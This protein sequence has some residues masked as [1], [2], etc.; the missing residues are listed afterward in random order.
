MPGGGGVGGG[1]TLDKEWKEG[2]ISINTEHHQIQMV[3][4]TIL[5]IQFRLRMAT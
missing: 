5:L 2:L 3:I 4:F 1:R